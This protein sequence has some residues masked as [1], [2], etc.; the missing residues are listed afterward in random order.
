MVVK[1]KGKSRLFQ[2]N[3]G[4]WNIIIWPD[5]STGGRFVRFGNIGFL[6]VAIHLETSSNAQRA[7]RTVPQEQNL[8]VA[9]SHTAERMKAGGVAAGAYS[10]KFAISHAILRH[11]IWDLCEK[12]QRFWDF[13]QIIFQCI[14]CIVSTSDSSRSYTE[15]IIRNHYVP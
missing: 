12:T 5:W 8:R 11:G 6:P 13:I 4:W 9:I 10:C 7:G 1:S 3:L 15:N 2:G 14:P